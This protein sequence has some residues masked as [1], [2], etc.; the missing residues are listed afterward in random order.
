MNLNRKCDKDKIVRLTASLLGTIVL[1]GALVLAAFGPIGQASAQTVVVSDQPPVEIDSKFRAEL[2][3]SVSAALDE[4]YVFPDV[5][6]EMGKFLRDQNKKGA[7]KALD[8]LGMFVDRL[9]EDL[10]SISHDRHLGLHEMPPEM[11]GDTLS[12][13][14]QTAAYLKEARHNNFGFYRV[15]RLTGNV[16]YLDL[17]GFADAQYARETAV[18]AMKFLGNTDALIIDLRKNGGGSPSMIQLITSYFF[19]EIKHLNSFY[20]RQQDSIQQFWTTEYVDGNRMVDQPIYILTSSYTF[21][22]AEEFTYNLKNLERATIVGET[23]GGGAHPVDRRLFANLGVGMQLPF[24]RA[25]NPITGTNWEG[26]G[27]EPHIAVPAD[28]AYDRALTEAMQYL[29]AHTD[30]EQSKTELQWTLDGI[31]ARNNPMTISAEK[32]QAYVGDYGPRHIMM[33]G[34]IL[35]YQRDERP[36]FAILP[37]GEDLFMVPDLDYFRI[38]F[39]RNSSGKVVAIVGLYDNGYTDRNDRD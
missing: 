34:D 27:I 11:T 13:E 3:D 16:G 8:K 1:A 15:E 20:I 14:E 33:E 18:A 36:K 5:A 30:S 22:A 39:E 12:D 31:K 26:T 21:S 2:I 29:I 35:N 32:M 19:D 4:I 10:R 37:M 28:Q 24:G 9:T 23:T 38:K 25:I 6:K 7:Y 17:R